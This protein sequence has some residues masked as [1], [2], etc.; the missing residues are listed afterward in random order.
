MSKQNKAEVAQFE[1]LIQGLIDHQYGCCNDFLTLAELAGLRDNLLAFRQKGTLK[2]AGIGNKLALHKDKSIRGDQVKWIDEQSS[3]VF[4]SIY[5]K[6][7]WRFIDYLNKS[8][9][10][11][12]LTFESHYANYACGDFYKRHLDQFKNEK[13]RKFSIVLYLNQDWKMEDGGLL[14]LY[15]ELG[16]QQNIS[17]MEG[18]LVLFRSDEMEHEVH[19]SPTRERSSIAGWMKN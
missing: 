7:I 11:S 15:P 3:N 5:L 4:E 12:I 8:C 17:P 16:A 18:R 2:N 6:K 13:G 14:S 1:G 19:P 10:T 9:F